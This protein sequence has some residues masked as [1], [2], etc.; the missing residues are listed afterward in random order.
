MDP[1]RE[2]TRGRMAHKVIMAMGVGR[3]DLM[4]QALGLTAKLGRVVVTNIHPYAE[5]QVSMNLSNLTGMEKQVVGSL[6][7]SA[8]P[9]ADIPKL[10][11]LDAQGQFDLGGLITRSYPL[12]RGQRRLPRPEG[13]PQH[14]GH[15]DHGPRT[16]R[17]LNRRTRAGTVWRWSKPGAVAW[18]LRPR[19]RSGQTARHGA[20]RHPPCGHQRVRRPRVRGLLHRGPRRSGPQ[21]PPGLRDRE[22]RGSTSVANRSTSSRRRCPGTWASTS[23][24]G[25]S[26]L[27][28]AVAELRSK[29]VAIADPVGSGTNRQTFLNDPSGNAMELHEVGAGP[30]I[31]AERNVTR[32]TVG[33][34]T[35]GGGRLRLTCGK[36]DEGR[37]HRHRLR[38][39][40][41]GRGLRGQRLRGD[42]RGH[43]PRPRCRA[44]AVPIRRRPG[45]G[46]LPTVPAPRARGHGPGGRSGRAVR[47][48]V[49]PLARTRPRPWPRQAE[50]AGVVNMV[51]F[52]FRHQ[53]ARQT[54]HQPGVIGRH[55]T[56]GAPR[57]TRRSPPAHGCRSGPG[58]GCSTARSEGVGSAPSGPTPSTSSAGCWA[59]WAAP[60]PPPGSPSPSV[61]T[62]TGKLVRCDAEDAFTGWIRPSSRGPR[63]RWIPHSPPESTTPARI[64]VTGTE[65]TLENVGD[66]RVV[67][68]R[69]GEETRHFE[70][71][72]PD[73]RRPP[74][75]HGGLGRRD[76][77]RR[78]RG[79]A[80]SRRRSPTA[81]PA[82]G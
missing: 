36:A 30:L 53:P 15:S 34:G 79:D 66:V 50:E 8:N 28:A 68:R 18:P 59:R 64:V 76:P 5:N 17:R 69:Q 51:N 49:R 72:R 45:L 40:G 43:G 58:A 38:G 42:R 74:P 6:F 32:G 1:I 60:E 44:G 80:R 54:M 7:G 33:C 70:F 57:P 16:G 23:P 65:G 46:P 71:D 25:S 26:D 4:D 75:G 41:G 11:E 63:P 67:L 81:W 56:A 12:E 62:P 19:R 35:T 52:E 47:Q 20:S 31:D 27:D 37:S 21:R 10:L 77:G 39:A 14:Q 2:L 13:R 82:C 48:A 22:V 24:S 78:D 73:G 61:P 29:G 3:G 55:R 9:R